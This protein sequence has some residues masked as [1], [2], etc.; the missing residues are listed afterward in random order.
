MASNVP[1]SL[2]RENQALVEAA[3]ENILKA[4][5]IIED[6]GVRLYGNDLEKSDPLGSDVQ[7]YA[8]DTQSGGPFTTD[9]LIQ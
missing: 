5:V 8:I 6:V 9:E 3:L 4:E 7:F 1:P 2:L